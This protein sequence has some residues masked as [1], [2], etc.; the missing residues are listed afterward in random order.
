MT[1]TTTTITPGRIL[2]AL[3][4][5]LTAAGGFLAD[6]NETHIYNPRWPPHAKFHNGQTM[7][8]G[9]LLGLSSLYYLFGR[10]SSSR[11]PR[12]LAQ[13]LAQEL[14][15]L[16][17]AAWLGS[18]YWVTQLSAALYPGSLPVDPEFGQGFPQA[19]ICVVLLSMVVV[20]TGL[21]HRRLKRM[22]EVK[23]E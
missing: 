2:L 16:W 14:S 10:S 18:L 22:M 8:M 15:S 6:M 20:G 11:E 12:A 19:Y 1:T 23:N 9:L 7:S 17:T 21:E 3:V 5:I 13:A 4:A